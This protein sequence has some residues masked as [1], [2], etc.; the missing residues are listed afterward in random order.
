VKRVLVTGA[1]GFI[2]RH[3]AAAFVERGW[4]VFGLLHRAPPVF[5]ATDGGPGTLTYLRGDAT[6]LE[7]L[8]AVLREC[9]EPPDAIVH[10]A[11]RASDVGWRRE[12]RRANYESVCH[13][14]L[15]VQELGIGR[16]VFVSTTDVYGL[17]DFNGQQ[18]DDMP[19]A[20]RSRNPYPYY[21]IRAER[22]IRESLPPERYVLL[23]PA[24]VWGPGD[25][26]ITPRVVAFL[27][28]SPAIVHFGRWRGRNRCPLV[29]V[30][31]VALAAVLAAHRPE[32][33]GQALNVIDDE[34]VSVDAF[35][36]KVAAEFLPGK[37]F[38]TV[39]LPYWIGWLLAAPVTAIS[40]LLNLR[41]PFADPSLYALRTVSHNL[42]FGN[43]RLRALLQASGDESAARLRRE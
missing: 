11:G 36:R 43:E 12:F 7:S 40:N 42:E 23:R 27:R 20:L 19:L 10:C 38:R 25:E 32:V 17:R 18:E 31:T 2:G 4:R 5:E 41:H 16:L 3:V 9:G 34:R 26:T 13:L 6:Q 37:R 15:L 1:A 28:H 24:Q 29:H 33:A 14:V 35:Y 30:G 22:Q 21:K 8:R 39:A